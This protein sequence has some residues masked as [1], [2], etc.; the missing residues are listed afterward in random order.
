MELL[1]YIRINSYAIK[2]EKSKQPP[3]ELIIA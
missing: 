3:F 2:L 1:E